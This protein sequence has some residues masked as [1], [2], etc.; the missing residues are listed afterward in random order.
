VASK[1]N[2]A[3]EP[4]AQQ[5]EW[6]MAARNGR[7]FIEGLRRQPREV[8]VAG[9]RVDDVTADP[10]FRR[11][12]QSIAQLY[13][14]QTQPQHRDLMTYACDGELAGSSFMIPR[15]HADLVKRRESMKIW[16]DATF[17]MV[18]RSP[19]Y[20]NTVLMTWAEGADFFGRRGEQFAR[21]VRDYYRYCREGDLFLTHAIVNPQSDRSKGS[22]QQEDTFVHLGVVKETGDGLVVRGAKML[23]T[24]GPTADELLV[25]PLPGLRSGEERYV[26][27]FAIPAATRGLRFICR[28]PFDAGAQTEWDHPLGARFEEPDAVCVFDDVLVPWDRVFL[29][30][31]VAMGNA[32][33]AQASIRNHTGHQTAIRGLAKCQLVTGVAIAMAR[34]VKSD[35]FLHVQEQLGELLS[36]LQL[37]EAAILLAERN[38]EPTGRGALRPAYAPLQAL[39]Y[40][41][42]KMYERMVQVTQVLGAAGLL[43]NPMEA[44]LRS[45]IGDD[46]ARYYRGAGVDAEKRIQLYKLAWDVTGTQFGQ[47]M[48]QYERYYAGDPVRVGASYYLDHDVEP[49]LAQVERALKGTS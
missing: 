48:L 31:D 36:H 34:T 14:L 23:A 3:Y 42:P 9:R 6:V 8:W 17:G 29:Y 2:A 44:D 16:A 5:G 33:F 38:A 7:E 47:R 20:L 49:L 12:V 19:D 13:D 26:L 11:P 24:H 43:I 22:H 30:G 32:L 10:V 46:I 18:G 40:Q 1:T 21:N 28:E 39:R 4:G 27:A 45:G 37:I 25:Y 35:V 41:L 15:T